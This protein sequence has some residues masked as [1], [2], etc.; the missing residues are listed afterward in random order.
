MFLLVLIPIVVFASIMSTLAV[1]NLNHRRQTRMWR[2]RQD[3]RELAK[4]RSAAP[5]PSNWLI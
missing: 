2:I 4:F 3:A 1:Q 5:S